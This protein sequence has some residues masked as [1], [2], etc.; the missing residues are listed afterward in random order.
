MSDIESGFPSANFTSRIDLDSDCLTGSCG[1]DDDD[2]VDDDDADAD[3]DD[4]TDDKDDCENLAD[5]IVQTGQYFSKQGM[6]A[7]QPTK[8]M[9]WRALSRYRNKHECKTIK[10]NNKNLQTMSCKRSEWR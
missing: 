7:R 9:R 2:D 6:F 5:E 4:D 3:N 8:A 10:A 1:G